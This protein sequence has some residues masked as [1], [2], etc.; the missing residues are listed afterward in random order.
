[1][2]KTEFDQTKQESFKTIVE[3]YRESVLL[4]NR[5]VRALDLANKAHS[6]YE[7]E[8]AK[9]MILDV[10]KDFKHIEVMG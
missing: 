10:A 6:Q 1:M 9:E 5:A 4:A 2:T 8:S 3:L 7:L